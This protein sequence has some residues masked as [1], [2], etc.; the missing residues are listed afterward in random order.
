MQVNLGT[1]SL[2]KVVGAAELLIDEAE[3]TAG[4]SDFVH[5]KIRGRNGRVASARVA[6]KITTQ[7]V[8]CQVVAMKN[9]DKGQLKLTCLREA[10]ADW[11]E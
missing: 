4:G 8:R 2:S 6:I 9:P 1:K 10:T 5:F 11:L 7:G 3:L